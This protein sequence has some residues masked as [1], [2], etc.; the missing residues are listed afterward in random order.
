MVCDRPLALFSVLW[1]DL[2]RQ[3]SYTW[4]TDEQYSYGWFVPILA[5]G[6]FIKKWPT[7]PGLTTDHRPRTTDQA[8]FSR[9]SFYFLLSTFC[10]FLLPL[11]VIHEI[12]QDWPIITWPM[13]LIVVAL[14]LYALHLADPQSQS[15]VSGPWSVVRSPWLRHFA[16]PVCFI[17]VA[18][19]WPYRIEHGLT[20]NLMQ[21]VA[22]LTV[23][24]LGWLDIPAIQR[25]NLIEISVG[26][27]GVDEACS[28]IRS[29]QST[30]MASLF[31]GELYLLRW[32]IR[33]LL[34]GV[35]LTVA[36]LLNIVRALILSWEANKNGMSAIDKW[37]DPAGFTIA[38]AC[39]LVVWAIA[40]LI[41]KWSKRSPESRIQH[42]ASS[43]QQ[44]AT[45]IEQ[46][47]TKANPA[48]RTPHSALR[49]YL[50]AVGLFSLLCIGI[51]ETWYRSRDFK[52]IEAAHWWVNYPTNLQTFR[53]VPISPFARKLLR[54]DQGI[55]GSWTEPDG[56]QWSVFCF[57]WRAGDPTARMSAMAHRPEYCMTGSGHHMNKDLGIQHL[58]ANGLNLPFR[59]Y[60][61]DAPECPLY[62]FFCLWEDGAEHQ[63]G[64]AITK[65]HNRLRAVLNRRRGL[66][67]QTLE[68]ICQGYATTEQ[69]KAA[70][71]AR[72]P[73]LIKTEHPQSVSNGQ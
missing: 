33:L 64:F 58:P 7:R 69:A 50:V 68:I 70:V 45:S 3:L 65:Y 40:L 20:Q 9:F 34:V 19:K 47:A 43:N 55:Q 73:E 27:L 38:A 71:T 21:V 46:P 29:F 56:T 72:L 63:G 25:G 54:Y 2:I 67:Q 15:A 1:L 26:T 41:S 31:L 30:L 8:G 62:V 24:V 6:L 52:P 23:E 57:R 49:T 61:F 53:E 66:G 59:T 11:R 42:P 35:G 36:F 44:P 10:F 13:T 5:L 18:V 17:L 4:Q 22:K 37:H 60:I 28:G 39:L 14:S 32:P 16:F 51:T 12:N 48:L